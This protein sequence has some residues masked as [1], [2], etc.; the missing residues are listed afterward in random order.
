[1]LLVAVVVALVV[2]CVALVVTRVLVTDADDVLVVLVLS[3]VG[4]AVFPLPREDQ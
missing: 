1:M 3:V 4:V 2:D